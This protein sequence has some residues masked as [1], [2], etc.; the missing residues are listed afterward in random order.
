MLVAPTGVAERTP[1]FCRDRDVPQRAAGGGH[2]EVDQGHHASLAED[3][4]LGIQVVVA[5]HGS[6]ARVGPVGCPACGRALERGRR[7]VE[8]PDQR[9]KVRQRQIRHRP[10]RVR[11]QRDIP[12]DPC[13]DVATLVVRAQVARRAVEPDRLEME[14]QV[15]DRGAGG[16][17]RAADRVADADRGAPGVHA[18]G[19]PLLIGH[20]AY[21]DPTAPGPSHG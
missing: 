5:D 17:G 7:V 18:S 8:P 15:T 9:A 1:G 12:V 6:A 16:S 14:Q 11:G 13:E 21:R 19:Q 3:H 4:V 20:G 10:G 2:R